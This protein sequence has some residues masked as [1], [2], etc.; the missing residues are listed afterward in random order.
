MVTALLR[1]HVD[2]C[3]SDSLGTLGGDDRA[4]LGELIIRHYG[5]DSP[6]APRARR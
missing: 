2:A 1:V 6:V 4:I 5:F 3:A